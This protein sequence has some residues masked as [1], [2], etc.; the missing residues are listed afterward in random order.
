[1][2]CF[3]ERKWFSPVTGAVSRDVAGDVDPLDEPPAMQAVLARTAST[4]VDVFRMG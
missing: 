2:I 3:S 4:I 1:V